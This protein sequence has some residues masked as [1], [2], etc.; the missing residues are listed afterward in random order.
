MRAN[1]T[2]S[3]YSRRL[4]DLCRKLVHSAKHVSSLKARAIDLLDR[5]CS[6][7]GVGKD[8]DS[9][10]LAA[11]VLIKH[12]VGVVDVTDRLHEIL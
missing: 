12:D 1:I 6:V 2:K 10:S 5:S 8:N 11:A 9:A 7:A 3:F 4:G